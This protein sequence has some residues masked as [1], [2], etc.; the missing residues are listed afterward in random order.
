MNRMW[1]LEEIIR[2][3]RAEVKKGMIRQT[4]R[5]IEKEEQHELENRARKTIQQRTTGQSLS[6]VSKQEEQVSKRDD[7]QGRTI[8][9]VCRVYPVK[10]RRGLRNT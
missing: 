9:A 6:G 2:M 3:N 1:H 10:S 5:D 7:E 4:Y 8:E